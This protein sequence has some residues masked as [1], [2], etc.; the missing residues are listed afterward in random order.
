MRLLVGRTLR[1]ARWC[2]GLGGGGAQRQGGQ[3]AEADDEGKP[4][5]QPT[6]RHQHG[7]LVETELESTKQ[8][9]KTTALVNEFQAHPAAPSRTKR[10]AITIIEAGR[11]VK[12]GV[13]HKSWA[14]PW[15]VRGAGTGEPGG[16]PLIGSAAKTPAPASRV[17]T[18]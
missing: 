10:R 17:G 15:A 2:L 11:A 3:L 5:P 4:L 6:H 18:R 12:T 7:V 8:P 1:R 16:Y 9:R 14:T 13:E